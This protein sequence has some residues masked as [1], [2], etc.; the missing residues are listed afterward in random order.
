MVRPG[1]P[2]H[3]NVTGDHD[4]GNGGLNDR[5]QRDALARLPADLASMERIEGDMVLDIAT[6]MGGERRVSE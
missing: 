6:G 5:G 4:G 2:M 3:R 1:R